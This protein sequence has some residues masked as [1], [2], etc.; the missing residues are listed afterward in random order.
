METI[1]IGITTRNRYKIFPKTLANIKKFQPENSRIEIVN[2]SDDEHRLGIAR[3]KNRCLKALED[4]EHI[5]LFDDDIYPIK[6]GWAEFYIDAATKTG[7]K[8][9]SL[10][11]VDTNFHEIQKQVDASIYNL[12]FTGLDPIKVTDIRPLA[13]LAHK[14]ALG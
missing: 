6:H 11:M 4:C 8:A 3:A 1:G 12:T 7:Y 9:F 13:I 5:F 14:Q 10:T 2:D